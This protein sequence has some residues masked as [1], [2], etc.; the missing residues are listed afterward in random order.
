MLR[1][2]PSFVHILYKET[3]MMWV[4]LQVVWKHTTYHVP[5]RGAGGRLRQDAE[6]YSVLWYL[7]SCALLFYWLFATET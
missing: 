1:N 2:G 3:A 7:L 6:N 5:W 4:L